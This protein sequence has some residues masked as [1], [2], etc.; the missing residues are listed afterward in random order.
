MALL[1]MK[2]ITKKIW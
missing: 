1:E 2:H